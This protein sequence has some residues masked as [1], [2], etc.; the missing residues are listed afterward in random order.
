MEKKFDH[1]QGHLQAMVNELNFSI[2]PREKKYFHINT[3]ENLIFHFEEIKTESDKNWIYET[4]QEY[5]RKCKEIV[6]S[7]DRNISKNLFYDNIEKL[8]NYYRNNLGFVVLIN[9]SI[10]YF[11]YFVVLLV[12]YL[13]FNFYVV[14]IVASFFVFQT[15]RVF[16]KYN[17]K[18][19]YS[20]FW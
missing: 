12:C 7:I 5:L 19:V 16:K 11:V 8:T 1:R 9:R 3:I 4:F 6:P 15:I 13:F 2:G 14:V 18:K 10:V 17:E 20:L